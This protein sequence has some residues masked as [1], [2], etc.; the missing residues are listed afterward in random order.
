MKK[1]VKIIF[2]SI[3]LIILFPLY[4]STENIPW[5][6]DAVFYEI[7]V[8]SFADS[9]GDKVGDLIGLTQ[10]INYLNTGSK[11]SEND[12][13]I[14]AIWLMPIF[15]SVSYH[16]YDVTD[17]YDINPEY[18]ILEDFE[19]FISE[20]HKRGIKVIL[21]LVV[22]H[23]S[24]KHPWFISASSSY[25]SPYRDYYVWST[26]KPDKGPVN[27]WYQ[28][29]TGYY[30]ALFWSEM[31]DL[32]FDNPK[33]REEVKKIAKFWIEKG[34][35][36]F[37]L[38]AAKH[39]YDENY[40]NISWWQEFYSY[41]RGI[42]PDIYLVGEVWD[43]EFTIAEY[44]KGL[45]SNFN[46]P[47][48]DKIISSVANQKDL[49]IVEFINYERDLF[50]ENNSDFA[51]AIFLRNH[52]QNRVKTGFGGNID[53]AILAASIYLTLPGT[54]FIYYGEEIGMEGA[55]PDE[56]IREPFKWTDNM[57]SPEQTYW[58]KP[59]YNLP[60]NGT[61][62]ETL[63]KDPKS[64]LNQYRKLIRS[65]INHKALALGDIEKV[66]TKDNSTLAYIRYY[67][68][69]KIL[70]IHNL[71]RVQNTFSLKDNVQEIIYLR[72]V[73]LNENELI[74]GAFS[75]AIVKIP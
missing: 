52:D 42:K 66:K 24:S 4:A 7:F 38:D 30:Y 61:S 35:D 50:R 60:N 16:G 11:E 44:Y 64:I 63:D 9:D 70:V 41:L 49:G 5:Y 47:L 59:F 2:I 29:P 14:D 54:P 48:S 45:P 57:K 37:R 33:V 62:V 28:K 74:L 55:K 51:D 23:T 27:L 46:F 43:N 12:L 31:P 67:G 25:T 6:K 58:I 69:E 13:K 56:Y 15:S 72:N 53:K 68:D 32:N 73:I 19:N 26:Q 22:N 39:I 1:V 40:K 17:Y 71:N 75:T 8:R 36:G 34:V 20:A 10:K 21:D 65:R 18:G 3:L